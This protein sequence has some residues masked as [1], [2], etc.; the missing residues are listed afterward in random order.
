MTRDRQVGHRIAAMRVARRLTQR[1][2]AE[3]AHISLSMLR[4][5]EQGSRPVTDRVL[6]AIAD[7]LGVEPEALTGRR[8]RSDSRVHAA[9]P[10]IRTAIDAYDVPDD[11]PVRPLARLHE[12]T[13]VAIRRRL[14]SQYTRLAEDLPPL[15]TELPRVVLEGGPERRSIAGLLAAAYRSADAVAYKYGYYDLSARLIELMRRSAQIAEDPALIATAAYVRTEVFF[16]GS[17]NLAPGLRALEIALDDIS[18]PASTELKA[19]AGAL[20]MRAA[21]VAARLTEDFS[22]VNEHLREA[23]RQGDPGGD[24]QRHRLRPGLRACARGLGRR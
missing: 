11:G 21:V 10:D 1:R 8:V 12:A 13:D 20:H 2:L 5:V 15:L 22:A 9:V 19:A 23:T 16:A 4:K 24:L 7:A 14:T 17:R 6:E 18:A 3:D